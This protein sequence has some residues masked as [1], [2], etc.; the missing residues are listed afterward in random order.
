MA[1]EYILKLR[2]KYQKFV[3]ESN[4]SSE[5]QLAFILENNK[6]NRRLIIEFYE[7]NINETTYRNYEWNYAIFVE[8]DE[9]GGSVC[10]QLLDT[11]EKY[12]TQ[13]LS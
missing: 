9:I 7:E 8:A 12:I 10:K 13:N 11:M 6:L 2:K 3:D 5:N 1:R 4:S